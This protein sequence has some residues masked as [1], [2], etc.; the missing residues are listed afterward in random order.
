MSAWKEETVVAP[1]PS[2]GVAATPNVVPLLRR[3]SVRVVVAALVSLAAAVLVAWVSRSAMVER[4]EARERVVEPPVAL[5]G[6]RVEAHTLLA[7]HCAPCHDSIALDAESD[8]LEVFD[9]QDSRWWLTMSD[10]Q[11]RVIVDRMASRDGMSTDDI[12]GITNYVAAELEFRAGG[13]T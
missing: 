5:A 8:A 12:A 6:M 7:A 9:V 13:H 4:S 2:F 1:E 11:L 10:R 3:R